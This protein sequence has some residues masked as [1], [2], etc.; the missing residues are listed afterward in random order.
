MK[1]YATNS[2]EAMSRVLAMMIV[3][4]AKIDDREITILDRLSAFASLNISRKDFMAVARDYCGDLR[5]HAEVEGSTP[6]IDPNRTDAV[7]DA[8]TERR[9][10]LIVA[11]L[12]WAIVSADRHH[13]EGELVLFSHILDR[14]KLARGEVAEAARKSHRRSS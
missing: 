10:R 9:P 12:M 4:D 2:P 13:D 3:A 11:Q 7:I 5:R 8:V 1:L 14:W 6:L